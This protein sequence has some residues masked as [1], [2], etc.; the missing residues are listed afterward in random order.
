[1]VVTVPDS[2]IAI[3]NGTL[4]EERLNGDGTV[5]FHWLERESHVNYLISLVVGKFARVTSIY[6]DIPLEIYVPPGMEDRVARSFSNTADM[7]RVFEDTFGYP[8]PYAKYAQSTIHDFRWGGME[9]VSAT[10]LTVRTLH[11]E[12]AHLTYRSDALV[13]EELAHQWFGDLITCESWQHIWLNEGFGTYAQLVYYESKWGE[14]GLVD[15]LLNFRQGYLDEYEESYRRPIVTE[16]YAEPD[17]LFDAHAYERGALVLHMLRNVLGEEVFWRGVR[18]YI[19]THAGSTVETAQ[20]K[21]A[22]EEVCGCDLDLFFDQWLEHGGHPQLVASWSWDE[23]LGLVAIEV[24]QVQ[25]IDDL[26]PIFETPLDVRVWTEN[27]RRDARVHLGQQRDVVHVPATSRPHLVQLD[28]EGWLLAQI[29]FRKGADAWLRELV[30]APEIIGRVGAAR[31]L[32]GFAGE[33][34]VIEGLGRALSEDAS[35]HVRAQAAASLGEL[36]T[37]QALTELWHGVLAPDARVRR[38]VA[39]ALGEFESERAAEF[40]IYLI[41]ADPSPYVVGDALE[42][43][44][45]TKSPQALTHLLAATQRSSHAETIR[46]GAYAGMA[47]LEDEAALPHLLAG[48]EASVPWRA[49][50]K[51]IEGLGSLAG[52]LPELRDA[53][54]P[55]LEQLVGDPHFAARRSAVEALGNSDDPAVL[56]FLRELARNAY[57]PG[58][59]S[60]ARDA[61]RTILDSDRESD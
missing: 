46:R 26:T 48:A 29:D 1:M 42:A 33:P 12:A 21:I 35:R 3:S 61:V 59:R 28:P 47:N 27:G 44:G 34:L 51:A 4:V 49:R 60:R 31:A 38:T 57:E 20:L 36:G 58:V 52:S 5:T 45:S 13:A 2:L 19:R 32:G 56:P 30:D 8:Y 55:R 18:H 37:E 6:R 53:I 54:R 22:F 25:L 17:D 9:N 14:D 39:G 23:E 43:L 40:L 11:D 16:T 15:R 41:D 7:M 50:S 24:E 10:T